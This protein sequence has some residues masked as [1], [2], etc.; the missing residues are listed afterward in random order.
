MMYGS[1]FYN[2]WAALIG[3]SL[4][5]FSTLSASTI[6]LNSLL[7]SFLAAMASFLLM[8][9]IRF[10]LAYVLYTPGDELFANLNKEN[11]KL[12]ESVDLSK[13][14]STDSREE[15]AIEFNDQSSEEI[16]KVV[17]T[18]MLQDESVKNV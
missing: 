12:S 9:G 15:G 16:A 5:F 10:L 8:F 13:N 6:P 11:E 17:Q 4:Y 3:F 18:M 7:G 1:I 14:H 2:L